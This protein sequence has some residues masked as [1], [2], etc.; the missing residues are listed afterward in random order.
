[1]GAE[2]HV[3]ATGGLG[4]MI[5]TGSKHIQHVDELLTL[6]GLRIIWERNAVR[7]DSSIAKEKTS[8]KSPIKAKNGGS[9]R[10]ASLS[11]SR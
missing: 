2:T 9:V 11:R 3:I 8:V 6:D 7:R 1:L 4:T 5:G 10:P